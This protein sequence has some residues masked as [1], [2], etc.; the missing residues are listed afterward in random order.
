MATQSTPNGCGQV[1]DMMCE[2]LLATS[3]EELLAEVAEDHGHPQALSKEFDRIVAPL[4]EKAALADARAGRLPRGLG[5]QKAHARTG[6]RF[7]RTAPNVGSR[8]NA[9][10]QGVARSSR[11]SL[12]PATLQIA[13]AS[14]I[15]LLLAA[16][17]AF[18]LVKEFSSAGGLEQIASR[19]ISTEQPPRSLAASD[20]GRDSMPPTTN[21]TSY[22]VDVALGRSE[23]EARTSYR[24]LRAN[25]PDLLKERDPIMRL[26]EVTMENDGPQLRSLTPTSDPEKHAYVT[27]I[28]PF[29]SA[30]KA[31]E[32]CAELKDLRAQC[33]G[34]EYAR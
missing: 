22:Y 27:S 3:R 2:D 15:V 10:L 6:H 29:A 18:L 30:E 1:A 28:G 12:F 21:P 16:G 32:F 11:A 31:K 13:I 19:S 25:F 23:A 9:R 4:L 24:V 5:S 14:L 8:L 34:V 7:S 26:A 20:R 33:T 17:V